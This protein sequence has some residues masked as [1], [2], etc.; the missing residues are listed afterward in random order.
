ML[1]AFDSFLIKYILYWDLR[2]NY[3]FTNFRNLGFI[4]PPGFER[5]ST[6]STQP[7]N[8]CSHRPGVQI[9]WRDKH[10]LTCALH[11]HRYRG[12]YCK[13]R[14]KHTK[15]N[16]ETFATL[17]ALRTRQKI[18]RQMQMKKRD[19]EKCEVRHPWSCL[20]VTDRRWS[21]RELDGVPSSYLHSIHT[22]LLWPFGE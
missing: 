3:L 9:E 2:M 17:L 10:A 6:Q 11:M 15:S 18:Q 7:I 14:L 4:K 5:E 20:P 19:R 1:Y 16:K 21:P 22:R 13:R 12:F 8:I